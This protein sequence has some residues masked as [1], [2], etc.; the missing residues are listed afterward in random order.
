MQALEKQIEDV[1]SGRFTYEDSRHTNPSREWRGGKKHD[2]STDSNRLILYIIRFLGEGGCTRNDI[3]RE[4][5]R[6]GIT[7]RH[8]MSVSESQEIGDR[9]REMQRQNLVVFVD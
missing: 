3:I 5:N 7:W 6:D 2:P 8:R 4:L 9:L 1:T